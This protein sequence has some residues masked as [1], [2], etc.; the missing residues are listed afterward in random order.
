MVGQWTVDYHRDVGIG[1]TFPDVSDNQIVV[2]PGF[3][4]HLGTKVKSLDNYK[5]VAAG[6]KKVLHNGVA[7][8][9]EYNCFI[10]VARKGKGEHKLLFE[11]LRDQK[12]RLIDDV[13]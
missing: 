7:D 11:I 1:T 12:C 13:S 3:L 6:I 8:A 10:V 4:D 2:D 5:A 9:K